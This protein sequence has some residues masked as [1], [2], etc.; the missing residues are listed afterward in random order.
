M[1]K[2]VA[3]IQGRMGSRRLPGKIMLHIKKRPLLEWVILRVRQSKLIDEIIVATSDRSINNPVVNL[4]KKLNVRCFMGSENNV[5]KRFYYA[6]AGVNADIVIRI[7]GDCPLIDA[8][9]ID[10]MVKRHLKNNNQYTANNTTNSYP[11]GFDLEVIN[12]ET[13]KL[14]FKKARSKYH[15][16]HVTTF[17]YDYPKRFKAEIIRAPEYLERPGLRLCV[18]EADDLVVVRKIYGHFFPRVYFSC[19]E[20]INFL[21]SNPKIAR[22]NRHVK[23]KTR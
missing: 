11:R 5:L 23:Q 9:I 6:A 12:F 1:K 16:E 4:C 22:I 2:I 18:D 10:E 7:T 8:A 14:M 13:L 20:I 15:K 19:K 17:I 3:I 21:D